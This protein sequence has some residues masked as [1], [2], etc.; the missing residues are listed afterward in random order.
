MS[1]YKFS[2]DLFLIYLHQNTVLFLIIFTERLRS[3][4][5]NAIC[6]QKHRNLRYDAILNEVNK[7]TDT[8]NN[9]RIAQSRFRL[10]RSACNMV[11]L[12]VLISYELKLP[13]NAFLKWN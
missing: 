13:F 10:K 5:A 9:K 11:L 8:A 1:G 2:N 7:V 3:L 4:D 12:N 6:G